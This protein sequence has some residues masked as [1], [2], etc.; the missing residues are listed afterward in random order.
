MCVYCALSRFKNWQKLFPFVR[1]S[2]KTPFLSNFGIAIWCAEGYENENEIRK[3]K[4]KK[5]KE[6]INHE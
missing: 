2:G 1:L 6:R 3:T 4:V 5:K